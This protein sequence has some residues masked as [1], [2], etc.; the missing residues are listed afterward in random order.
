VCGVETNGLVLFREVMAVCCGNCRKH[1]SADFAA[2]RSLVLSA[3]PQNLLTPVPQRV[4]RDKL[5]L[6]HTLC[7][8]GECG[9]NYECQHGC[10][11]EMK[12]VDLKLGSLFEAC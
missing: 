10:Y 7:E 9:C 6:Y 5:L 2:I 4:K 3:G 11:F 8:C 1:I 12:H